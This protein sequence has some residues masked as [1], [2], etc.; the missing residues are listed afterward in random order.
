MSRVR[1][2]PAHDSTE[3]IALAVTPQA[4][5]WRS[6]RR[7]RSRGRGKFSTF[8]TQPA[9]PLDEVAVRT[10]PNRL[11]SLSDPFDRVR[12]DAVRSRW[13]TASRAKEQSVAPVA[14]DSPRRCQRAAGW[15]AGRAL[16]F[17]ALSGS[18]VLV[19]TV[20]AHAIRH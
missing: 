12:T 11:Q 2:S 20:D 13:A 16:G 5:R 14:P 7:P 1:S 3:T 6:Y 8:G 17:G 9:Q 15:S 4:R 18:S 19:G 10:V